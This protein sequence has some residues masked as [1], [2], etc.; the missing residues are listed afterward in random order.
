MPSTLITLTTDFGS[1]DPF[2]GIMKGVILGINPTASIVDLTHGIP[3][4]NIMRAALVVRYSARY[5]P[6]GTIHV[7]IVDPGVGSQRRPL[8]IQAKDSFYV[9]PDNGI[10]SLALEGTTPAKVIELSNETYYLRPT[11]AT[12]HGRDIF[13]AVAGYLS[14]GIPPD[15]FG[16]AVPG[17]ERLA[18][19]EPVRDNGRIQGEIVYVDSFGNLI[20]NIQKED[21]K[22]LSPSSVVFSLGSITI[23]GV[24]PNYASGADEE[25]IALFNSWDLLEISRYRGNAQAATGMQVGDKV[26]IRSETTSAT[27]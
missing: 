9:G 23:R 2:A 21:L 25:Y 7:A 16:N 5:F 4:Q 27:Q 11:S 10:F 3:A 13:A 1:D 18:W 15:S 17:F 26:L 6:A 12:F 24:K 14:L 22:G 20:T 19:H 8:L